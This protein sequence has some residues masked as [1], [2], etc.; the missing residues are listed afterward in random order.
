MVYITWNYWVFGP[1]PSS[2]ILKTQRF[3][4]WICFRPQ[5]GWGDALLCPLERSGQ[6]EDGNRSIFR[7]VVFSSSL[8]YG[9]WNKAPKPRN[10]EIGR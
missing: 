6:P 2:G 4:N 1:G 5:V 9:T 3:G 7:N 10:F 8:G